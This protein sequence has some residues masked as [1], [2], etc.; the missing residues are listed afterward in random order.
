MNEL[1]PDFS[2]TDGKFLYDKL[3]E[4]IKGEIVDGRIRQGEKLPSTRALSS[5]LQISRSTVSLS[6]DQLLA[7]GYIKAKKGSGFFACAIEQLYLEKQSR[8]KM[9]VMIK[10]EGR[11]KRS[12]YLYDFSPTGVD[13]SEFPIR[14]W[15]RLTGKVMNE[16]PNCL[17]SHGDACGEPILREAIREYLHAARGV[18]CESS[19]I[20]VG[21][22]NDCLLML[23][24]VLL[25]NE[26]HIAFE[27]PTYQ[28]AYRMFCAMGY[29]V[30]TV[31]MDSEGINME[32]L[33]NSAASI[34]YVMPSHQYPTGV[35]MPIGRR[36]ELLSWANREKSRYLIEDDY[37][38]E[39]RYRGKP[40]PS[41]QSIDTNERVIYL[42]T[43]SKSIAPAIRVSYMVLPHKLLNIFRE[44]GGFLSS[45]VSRTE[46]R[47]LAEF[48]RQGLFERYLNRMRNLYLKK[49]DCL[50]QALK[51]FFKKFSISGDDAGLHLLLTS[52]EDTTEE[53][54][55]MAAAKMGVRVYGMSEYEIDN[56]EQ[57]DDLCIKQEK[58]T[59]KQITEKKSTGKTAT[60]LL[61][62][63]AMT[64]EQIIDGIEQLKNAWL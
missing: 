36:M 2:K 64:S 38:S 62:Y 16:E 22:G 51:P 54:L 10:A 26:R 43:F 33:L 59:E 34:A 23:L 35:V 20:I 49:H 37:D 56:E 3:Y 40:I 45:T 31:R 29:S 39:F 60:V 21:A 61:G 14:E 42:G 27:D 17:L 44:R 47:V 52:K 48:I 19:Q 13:I 41:L 58:I 8:D 24:Q 46:Q 28:K 57:K 18:I 6:Y 12:P 1:T 63:A 30:T 7:E 15:K 53:E 11:Q 50:M 9:G 25:G 4:Y 5:Y 55:L 32:D